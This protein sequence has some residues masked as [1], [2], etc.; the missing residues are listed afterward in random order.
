MTAFDVWNTFNLVL[1]IV[2]G[3]AI[4]AYAKKGSNHDKKNYSTYSK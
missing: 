1:G 2:I 3:I 4:G